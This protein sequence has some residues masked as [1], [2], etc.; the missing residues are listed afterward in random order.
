[1][2][3][4]RQGAQKVEPAP[5]GRSPPLSRP[6]AAL[7]QPPGISRET[8][9]APK[10]RV[11]GGVAGTRGLL[12][13]PAGTGL[14]PAAPEEVPRL[15]SFPE[16]PRG[17]AGAKP[18]AGG[19]RGASA[20]RRQPPGRP[21]HRQATPVPRQTGRAGKWISPSLPRAPRGSPTRTYRAN[22]GGCEPVDEAPRPG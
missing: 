22:L 12:A 2:P 11:W 9:S 10:P 6:L 5:Q 14:P 13:R 21:R 19:N 17:Q 7:P 3:R 8:P 18:P 4:G 1:M 16:R 20:V 15:A